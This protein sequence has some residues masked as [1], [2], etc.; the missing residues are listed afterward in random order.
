[1]CTAALHHASHTC[2]DRDEQRKA[3]IK[4]VS[5]KVGGR[6]RKQKVFTV[7]FLFPEV[8]AEPKLAHHVVTINGECAGLQPEE[9]GVDRILSLV[10]YISHHD[11]APGHAKVIERHPATHWDHY[12]QQRCDN[13]AAESWQPCLS[14]PD[15]LPA[16]I[17][18]A[19]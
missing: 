3:D 18:Q 15:Y 8:P 10:S 11:G 1:M 9:G 17:A 5:P 6:P 4:L 2:E 14:P 7:K 16:C 19:K 13:T 12:D